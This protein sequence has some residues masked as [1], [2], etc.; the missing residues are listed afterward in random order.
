[1]LVIDNDETIL[2]GMRALLGN[3]GLKVVAATG[4]DR[5]EALAAA[6]KGLA[7]L[8]ADYHLEDDLTGDVAVAKIR[9]LHPGDLP[10]VIVTADRS[11]EVKAKLGALDLPVLTKPVKPAQLRAL[12][13]RLSVAN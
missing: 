6:R 9:A 2:D 1:M 12:L 10:A 8:I 5:E 13:R 7:L 4:P 3:W 11:E